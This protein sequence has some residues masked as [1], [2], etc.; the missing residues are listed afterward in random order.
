MEEKY[1]QVNSS[2]RQFLY[3]ETTLFLP[4]GNKITASLGGPTK[5]CIVIAIQ[6]NKPVAYIDRVE[7]DSQCSLNGIHKR[8][9]GTFDLVRTALWIVH[10]RFPHIT[11]FTLKDDSHI[12]CEEDSKRYKLNLAYDYILKYGETWY[13]NKFDATLPNNYYEDFKDSIKCITEPLDNI[14]Y[15]ISRG[16]DYLESYRT[17]YI[18]SSS[19]YDFFKKLRE[20]YGDQYCHQVCNWISKY[21]ILLGVKLFYDSWL[22]SV[23]KVIEP[24]NYSILPKKKKNIY[25][26]TRRR[27]RMSIRRRKQ[28]EYDEY[29]NFSGSIVGVYGDF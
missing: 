9:N 19:P 4:G 25:G 8:Q 18:D 5:M 11:V 12:N 26:G 23:D 2:G 22:I 28:D 20:Q 17:T 29:D 6:P 21:M 16:A 27:R 1:F 13:Q 3:K 10:T 24:P 15:L 7:Y 14:D